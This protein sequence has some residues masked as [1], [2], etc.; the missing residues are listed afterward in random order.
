[1][2]AAARLGRTLAGSGTGPLGAFRAGAGLA[3]GVGVGPVV[4]VVEGVGPPV[5]GAL[6]TVGSV[7]STGP[8]PVMPGIEAMNELSGA[9]VAVAS[10]PP[11]TE[12]LM[13]DELAA[14]ISPEAA[15]PRPAV[16]S[17]SEAIVTPAAS[18]TRPVGSWKRA[19]RWNGSSMA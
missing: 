13:G 10:G 9:V 15:V 1:M 5:G 18:R 14:S 12:A 2:E 7:V 6:V 3:V 19:P 8:S 11:P 16:S 17:T 4:G